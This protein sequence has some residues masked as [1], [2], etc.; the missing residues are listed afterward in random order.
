MHISFDYPFESRAASYGD[1]CFTTAAIES[2][3]IELLELHLLRLKSGCQTLQIPVSEQ[4]FLLLKARLQENVKTIQSGIAKVL[5]SAGDGGR[6]YARGSDIS[7]KCY[8]KINEG[9]PDYKPWQEQGV[10]LSVAKNRL[11]KQ[12]ALAGLKHLNRLEQS[13][14]KL[15]QNDAQDMLVLDTDDKIVEVTAGNVFWRTHNRWFTPALDYSGVAGVMRNFLMGHF[16]G[17]HQPVT[18]IRASVSSLLQA[19]DMLI[20]NSLMR[21]VP[22]KE[23]ELQDG[24]KVHFNNPAVVKLQAELRQQIMIKGN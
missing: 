10:V 11:G 2:G 21:V 23:L 9:Q 5:I 20:C 14:I 8:I 19:S 12:P 18:Q 6:G 3:N 1:G 22:V 13:L 17:E 7:A 24:N 15:E 16:Q 4:Q